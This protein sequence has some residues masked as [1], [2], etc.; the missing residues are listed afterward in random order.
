MNA[1]IL[2]KK[3]YV[4]KKHAKILVLVDMNMMNVDVGLATVNQTTVIGGILN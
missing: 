3:S 2:V 4:L 1:V